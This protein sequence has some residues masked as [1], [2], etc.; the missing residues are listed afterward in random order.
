MVTAWQ[1]DRRRKQAA[2]LTSEAAAGLEALLG[3]VEGI[4]K[5]QRQQEADKAS[6]AKAAAELEA[7][8]RRGDLNEMEIKR[9]MAKDA[10]DT[11]RIQA[12]TEAKKAEAARKAQADADVAA[13]RRLRMKGMEERQSAAVLKQKRDDAVGRLRADMAGGVSRADLEARAAE[14]GMSPEQFLQA[15]DEITM[16]EERETEDRA[17][18]LATDTA[19]RTVLTKKAAPKPAPSPEAKSQ[20]VTKDATKLRQEFIKRP[21]VVDEV[22]SR[23]EFRKMEQA[24]NNPSAGGDLALVFSFMKVLDP[25]S[26]VR[27]GEFANAQNATGV[28][29][30]VRNEWNRVMSGQRLSPEQ[31]ADFLAQARTFYAAQKTEADRV[32]AQYQGLA[33]RSGLNPIDVVGEDEGAPAQAA[34]TVIPDDVAPVPPAKVRVELDG[35]VLEIDRADLPDALADGAKVVQ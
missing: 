12:E 19:K 33:Q 8:V 10:A 5:A 21:E 25:G 6:K 15:A 18:K 2:Q 3:G 23:V 20:K 13:E 9:R 26:T 4:G 24:A 22:K 16:A 27:E 14:V 7:L 28:P 30:R 29:E 11:E 35:D 31:R 34:A 17:A 32:R 1:Q